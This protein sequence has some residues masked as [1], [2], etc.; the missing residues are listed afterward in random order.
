[1]THSEKFKELRKKWNEL[2]EETWGEI[3][4]IFDERNVSEIDLDGVT[5][6]V[7]CGD[8][9]FDVEMSKLTFDN[10]A[11]EFTL[12]DTHGEEYGMGEVSCGE[13]LWI[14]WEIM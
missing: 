1:M 5:I 9:S 13:E 3:V 7:T 4:Q 6:N 14:Y 8:E 12:Y 2:S 10:E 11:N